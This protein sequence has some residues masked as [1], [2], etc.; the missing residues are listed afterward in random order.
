[1]VYGVPQ[2]G[3]LGPLLLHIY[4]NDLFKF[5]PSIM[6]TSFADDTNIIRSYSQTIDKA[7]VV[8]ES[9]SKYIWAN[10]GGV[11]SSKLEKVF[12]AQKYCLRILFGDTD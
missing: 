4:M 5:S 11:S 10:M 1:V 6:L 8:L 12:N 9:V 3:V 2:G 7:N